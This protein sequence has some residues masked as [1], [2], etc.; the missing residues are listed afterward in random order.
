[1]IYNNFALAWQQKR[2]G[3]SCFEDYCDSVG[4]LQRIRS[5]IYPITLSITS[6]KSVLFWQTVQIEI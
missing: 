6:L 5:Y 3:R 4:N 2:G 1:M